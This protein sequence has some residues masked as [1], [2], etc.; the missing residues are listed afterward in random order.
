LGKWGFY[1]IRIPTLHS[2]LSV[3]TN[4]INVCGDALLLPLLVLVLEIFLKR[5][6]SEVG[7][8]V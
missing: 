6:V 7:A 2:K 3:H 8:E 1:I 4:F 5:F